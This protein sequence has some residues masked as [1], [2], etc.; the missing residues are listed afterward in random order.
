MFD[1]GSS[2]YADT[3][4]GATAAAPTTATAEAT[5]RAAKRFLCMVA[6]S[7][8]PVVDAPQSRALVATVG[9]RPRPGAGRQRAAVVGARCGRRRGRV[10]QVGARRVVEQPE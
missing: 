2:M 5:A 9:R 8:L 7:D 3:A 4:H 10:H 6:S 1:F